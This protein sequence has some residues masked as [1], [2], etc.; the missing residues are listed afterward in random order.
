MNDPLN[1]YCRSCQQADGLEYPPLADSKPDDTQSML[2]EECRRP[3]L[4]IN[5]E[6]AATI[7]RKHPKTI[8]EWIRR[9]RVKTVRLAD[10]R[11]LI[12]YTSLFRPPLPENDQA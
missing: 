8:R 11:Y 2:C 6:R 5:V 12:C 4:F 3:I 7:T 1:N 10:N 9:G